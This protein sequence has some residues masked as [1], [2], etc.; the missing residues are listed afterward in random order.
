M[1]SI[2]WSIIYGFLSLLAG[3][4]SLSIAIY[5]F[6]YWKNKSVRLLLLLVIAVSLWSFA[7]GMEFFSPSLILKLWWVKVEYIGAV[8][9]GIL[10]FSFI[11][12]ISGKKW[13]VTK[14]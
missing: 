6:P 2:N 3:F 1:E 5:L 8:W 12:I 13:Q 9:V 7:Y 4:I 14:T 11:I 10:L